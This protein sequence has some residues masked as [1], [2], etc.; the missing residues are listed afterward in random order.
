MLDPFLKL[1]MYCSVAAGVAVATGC[2]GQNSNPQST[3][4][5]SSQG[6][7]LQAAVVSQGRYPA[8]NYSQE[9]QP[10]YALT[11]DTSDRSYWTPS[12]NEYQVGN[13]R[14]VYPPAP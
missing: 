5:M 6:G 7:P 3:S 14:I 2:N 12:G 8:P 9:A 13:A 10:A 1:G 4:G 11:G